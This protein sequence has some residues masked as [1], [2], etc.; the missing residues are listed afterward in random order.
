MN[1]RIFKDVESYSLLWKKNN[2]SY[3]QIDEKDFVDLNLTQCIE[4][5]SSRCKGFDT[6]E[7]LRMPINEET[8]TY[9]QEI[10]EDLL[11]NP[12]LAVQFNLVQ[13]RTKERLSLVKFAF[14]GEATVYNLLKRVEESREVTTIFEKFFQ[15]LKGSNILSEG[16]TNLSRLLDEI[17][18]STI[19][20]NFIKDLEQ[21]EAM[22]GNI[23]SIRIGMNFDENL[24]PKEGIILSMGNEKVQ[25]KKRFGKRAKALLGVTDTP[26][27]FIPRIFASVDQQVPEEDLNELEILTQPAFAQLIKFCDTY[28]ETLLHLMSTV[29]KDLSFYVGMKSL[30]DILRENDIPCSKPVISNDIKLDSICNINLICKMINEGH[31]NIVYNSIEMREDESCFIFTGAN[32]G[33]KTTTTQ[34][35]GQI[36]LLAQHGFIL[37]GE[38]IQISLSSSIY[39]IFPRE[40]NATVAHGRLG[41]ECHR[42]SDIFDQA[43]NRSLVLLN[44]T[45][46][47]TSHLESLVMAKEC[48]KALSLIGCKVL[49]NTHLHELCETLVNDDPEHSYVSLV[50]GS[51]ENPDSFVIR[52]SDAL[53]K[54]YAKE[55]AVKYGVSYEQLMGC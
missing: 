7:L 22:K 5:I 42:Y 8:V 23:K 46:S 9:R 36:V 52:R 24:K 26:A 39:M 40:E 41:E 1:K 19:Y 31:V 4:M 33:G 49:F 29:L 47:G 12:D 30:H 21:V 44:E 54:S 35:L 38:S 16:L 34:A 28:N 25:V 53:G 2:R 6:E 51:K 48:M 17:I 37:P 20:V 50:T 45:F 43:D 15:S 11:N 14:E 18:N 27:S 55:I 13:T 3:F 32:R 10:L